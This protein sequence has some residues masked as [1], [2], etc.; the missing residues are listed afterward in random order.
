MDER[1]GYI[2]VWSHH[3]QLS[4]QN[5][6]S[7]IALDSVT[8]ARRVIN[9]IIELGDSVAINPYKYAECAELPSKNKVYRSV[10]YAGTYKIIYKI[11][12]QEIWI[13]DIFHGKRNPVT[14]K[15]LRR[16]KSN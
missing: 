7:F 1:K 14:L 9:K 5:I 12:K 15:K 13:L 16:I 6:G 2:V 8:Q 3:A 4:L 10:V 11:V